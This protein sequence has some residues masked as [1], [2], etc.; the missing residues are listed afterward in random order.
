M[1]QPNK[2]RT[3]NYLILANFLLV[4]FLIILNNTN[5]F[6]LQAGDFIFF[7]VLTLALALYRPGWAFLFFIGTIVLENI[8]LAP[9]GMGF[10]LRPYQVI[11]ALTALAVIIRIVVRRINFSL[12]KLNRFDLL[13]GLIILFSF[14]SALA[15]PEKT[16]SLKLS[17]VLFSFLVLYFLTKI[18]IQDFSDLKK[19]I[20]LF[21]TSL[22]IVTLYG[23][24]QNTQA[25]KNLPAFE[26]MPG[27]PN[28]TFSEP[29]WLGIFLVFSLAALYSLIIYFHKDRKKIAYLYTLLTLIIILILIT[30]SR[31]AWIGTFILTIIFLLIILSKLS[32]NYLNWDY[33]NFLAQFMRITFCFIFSLLIIHFFHLTDFKLFERAQSSGG[34]QKITIAC[35][36]KISGVAIDKRNSPWIIESFDELTKF[37]CRHINLEDI[38]AERA[39]GNQIEFNVY[40]RDPNINVRKEIYQKSWTEIKKHP[41]M[42]IGWG[43]IG[44]ILGQDERGAMLNSSNIFLEVWLGAGIVGL[45]A[46]ILIWIFILINGIRHFQKDTIESRIYG[47]FLI[48]GVLAILIPNFF[49]AGILLGFLWVFWGLSQINKENN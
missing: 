47:I 39:L 37:G 49:N 8:N 12:P 38:D 1:Q 13:V 44:K 42:G 35:D 24:W 16:T 33:K 29:D 30:V 46:F 45:I 20:P 21:L 43:S 17:L 11:G 19:I 36:P 22:F 25:V 32:W 7:A 14:F 10:M 15:A 28:A 9:A 40:R 34:L 48:L 23:I 31:S 26:V 27:R 2:N 6:P 3:K 4:F 18:Y 41:V 5:F